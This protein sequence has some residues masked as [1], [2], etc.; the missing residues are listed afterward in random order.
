MRAVGQI[1]KHSHKFESL[2]NVSIAQVRKRPVAA[3]AGPVLFSGRPGD[4]ALPAI[5]GRPDKALHRLFGSGSEPRVETV[6]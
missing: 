1:L 5:S 3:M 6:M 4:S 2:G